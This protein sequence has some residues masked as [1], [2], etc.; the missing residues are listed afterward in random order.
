MY[1]MKKMD[2]RSISLGKVNFFYKLLIKNVN[3]DELKGRSGQFKADTLYIFAQCITP[4][5]YKV[6]KRL[7]KNI[8]C[9]TLFQVP[10][11]TLTIHKR[12]FF[13]HCYRRCREHLGFGRNKT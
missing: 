6:C 10:Y 4:K 1:Y 2:F 13:T 5:E 7:K 3:Y 9:S 11:E 12:E 8:K